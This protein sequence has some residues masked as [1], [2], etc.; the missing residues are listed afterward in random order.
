MKKVIIATLI[1]LSAIPSLYASSLDRLCARL[2]GGKSTSIEFVQLPAG[3]RESYVVSGLPDGRIRI[4]GSTPSAMAVGLNRYLRELCHTDVSWY[5]TDS[6]KLPDT[7]PIPA[8]PL[9]GNA[10]AGMRF[11]LNYCTF[12]Y[13]MPF[14]QWSDWERLIDW[15]ALQGINMPLSITG[16]EAVWQRVWRSF[17]L[18]GDSVRAYFTGPAHLPWHRML[19]VDRWEGPLPQSYIDS[20]E[21]LQ[22]K[23]VARERELGMK[24][25]LP[26]FAGHVPPE[27]SSVYPSVKIHPMSKWGG[28]NPDKYRS[29]FIEPS[30]PLFDSIQSRFIDELT[31]AFGTDHIYGLDP[32]NEIEVPSWEEEYLHNASARISRSLQNAD[33][34]ARWLQMGWMFY[35]MRK[36]WTPERVRAFLTGVEPERLIM[37]D[38]YCDFKEMWRDLEK[39]HG[40]PFIWCYLGNFGGNTFLAGDMHKVFSRTEDAFSELGGEMAG[41]G[42]TLE[43]LDCNPHMHSYVLDRAWKHN[44]KTQQPA[45]W[46]TNW[47][48]ARGGVDDAR[49]T[50]AWQALC[51][52]IYRSTSTSQG[53]LINARPCLIGHNAWTTNTRYTYDNSRLVEI[54]RMLA[55]ADVCS[56]AHDFDIVNIGRQVLGNHFVTLRDA[57]TEAYRQHD[58]EGMRRKAAEMDGLIAE[59]DTLLSTVQSFNMAKWIADARRMGVTPDEADYYE[60]NARRLLSTWG[61]EGTSLNDYANR[62]WAGLTGTFYRE[63]W[64]R[65]TE[66]LIACVESGEEFG[67]GKQFYDNLKHWEWEWAFSHAPCPAAPATTPAALSLRLLDK[68]FN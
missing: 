33:P 18:D 54:W 68:Y 17:G 45:E 55:E 10:R 43:G 42:G 19:N 60:A 38:Y 44:G 20:Q 2:L 12:G 7:L 36:Q 63:R 22:K 64:R 21:E 28:L 52:D 14:W 13:T 47:A 39:F 29:Y 30:E 37:L 9:S 11:F 3:D 41:I 65:F 5:A 8:E 61:E 62:N 56:P 34:E 4:E 51:E 67:D 15:M 25:I 49:V 27:L 32:F 57:F 59:L 23:I 6:L 26:A 50:D 31:K 66:A 16:Q 40:R 48:E 53:C 24:P 58:I 35:Y 46:I 1:M